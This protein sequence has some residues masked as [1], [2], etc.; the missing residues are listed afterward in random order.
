MQHI[1]SVTFGY[2]LMK[3]LQVNRSAGWPRVGAGV[4]VG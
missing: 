3:N 1:K 4:T 2:A